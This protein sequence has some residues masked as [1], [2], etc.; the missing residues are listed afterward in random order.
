MAKRN[1]QTESVSEETA[2]VKQEEP[3]W[4]AGLRAAVKAGFD[5]DYADSL[6]T[7]YYDPAQYSEKALE[8]EFQRIHNWCKANYD[9][10][11]AIYP[12]SKKSKTGESVQK[13]LQT[14]DDLEDAE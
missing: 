5:C 2:K 7:F 1:T 6:V 9:R 13:V 12:V 8:E 3:F 4:K 14:V 10:S 11:Y